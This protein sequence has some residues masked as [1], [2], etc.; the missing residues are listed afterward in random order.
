MT[1]M[2]SFVCALALW[3]GALP[4]AAADAKSG[5]SADRDFLADAASGGL[6]EVELGRY[7]ADHASNERVKQ[8]GRRM[9]DD[10]GKAN[11]DLEQVA[12]RRSVTLPVTMND[13]HRETVSRL[14]RLNGA[15]FDRAY[16][17]AMVEDHQKDVKRF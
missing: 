16:M 7:A 10:H 1:R 9:A 2:S 11:T 5:A 14:T 13:E 17:A 4:A 6:M 15:D 8:F 12:A 3:A